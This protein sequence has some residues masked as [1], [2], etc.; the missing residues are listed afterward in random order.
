MHRFGGFDAKAS[1]FRIVAC[2]LIVLTQ[3]LGLGAAWARPVTAPPRIP[4]DTVRRRPS[5]PLKRPLNP[6]ASMKK[7]IVAPADL[8]EDLLPYAARLRPSPTATARPAAARVRRAAA[9][10]SSTTGTGG[11][12]TVSTTPL[13][14]AADPT[15]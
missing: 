10:T 13:G 14:G 6:I 2:L 7:D 1:W 8:T 9:V 12:A 4:T 3:W 15:D 11:I 5:S